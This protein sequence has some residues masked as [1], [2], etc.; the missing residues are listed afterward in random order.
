MPCLPQSKYAKVS[1]AAALLYV[2]AALYKMNDAVNLLYFLNSSTVVK[3]GV[4][5]DVAD[6]AILLDINPDS[7]IATDIVNIVH[8]PN[9]C[10]IVINLKRQ[11]RCTHLQLIGRLSGLALTKITWGKVFEDNNQEFLVGNYIVPVP[12]LYY[13]EI[14][15]NMCKELE[16]DTNFRNI[17]LEDPNRHRLTSKDATIDAILLR[18]NHLHY[19]INKTS[20]IGYWY[21][22]REKPNPLYTRYQPPFCRN[23]QNLQDPSCKNATDLSRF[24]PYEFQF[25]K[26]ISLEK[27]L[28]N[29]RGHKICFV[30]A[31]H[32]QLIVRRAEMFRN[33]LQNHSIVLDFD[34]ANFIS[35]LDENKIQ[36]L[37][38]KG[39]TKVI[40]ATGQWDAGWPKLAPTL[41]SKYEEQLEMAIRMMVMMFH[42][43]NIDLYF[44]STHYNPIG[45]EIGS[46]PPTNWRSPPVIDMYN[47]ITKRVCNK[48]KI[49]LIETN[50]IIGIMWDRAADWC[51][52][53]DV[54]S[55]MEILYILDRL[56]V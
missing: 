49:P 3:T 45:Y 56:F 12:G 47:Q 52:Y 44:R 31:S 5:N 40:M 10:K 9:E 16:Y 2:Y 50:D 34:R 29:I 55:D 38:E 30:G 14:I 1:L 27:R 25:T 54:S 35:D 48:F 8:L 6:K 41:F 42:G 24:S 26:E 4:V 7:T 21:N 28:E 19:S 22:V 17:C 32:N 13:I 11:R 39:C 20:A 36:I 15:V 46:C 18:D 33:L 53:E 23:R 51:H 43:T 37:I